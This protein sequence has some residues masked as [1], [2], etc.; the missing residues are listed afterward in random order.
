MEKYMRDFIGH[1]S[2]KDE[3]IFSK[4]FTQMVTHFLNANYR[5]ILF[6][7]GKSLSSQ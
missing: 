2:L 1:E 3:K 7:S 6:N 5:K 4:S